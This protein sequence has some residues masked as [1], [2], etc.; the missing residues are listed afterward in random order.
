VGK[1]GIAWA[2]ESSGEFG[3]SPSPVIHPLQLKFHGLGWRVKQL[4]P[5]T[6]ADSWS[7]GKLG[8]G[9]CARETGDENLTPVLN[10]PG[11][12]KKYYSIAEIGSPVALSDALDGFKSI[13]GVNLKP[14][15]VPGLV[16]RIL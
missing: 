12:R 3:I 7:G 14:P 8:I 1:A 15:E 13:N 2:A 16:K 5:R 10:S 9:H 6:N 11:L 4:F